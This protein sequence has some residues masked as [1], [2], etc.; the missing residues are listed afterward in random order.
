MLCKRITTPPQDL[1]LAQPY[2]SDRRR[3]EGRSYCVFKQTKH[4]NEHEAVKKMPRGGEGLRGRGLPAEL[5]Q[6]RSI[7]IIQMCV[8]VWHPLKRTFPRVETRRGALFKGLKAGWRGVGGSRWEGGAHG[9]SH[10]SNG[11]IIYYYYNFFFFKHVKRVKK[12]TIHYSLT[13]IKSEI[14]ILINN[15][16]I[17]NTC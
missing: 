2:A 10:G 17:N 5:I 6:Q 7:L 1:S 14:N 9:L 11:A 4:R 13:N 16:S 15:K 12:N 8:R 3:W